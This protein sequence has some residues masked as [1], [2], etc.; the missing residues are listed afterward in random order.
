M[1]ILI[2]KNV[3]FMSKMPYNFVSDNYKKRFSYRKYGKRK[4][5][6]TV[7]GAWRKAYYIF[8]LFEK[9]KKAEEIHSY[10]EEE[11]QWECII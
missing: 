1:S 6:E 5:K 8:R 9:W 10:L 2:L 7:L 4:E 11:Y 3:E